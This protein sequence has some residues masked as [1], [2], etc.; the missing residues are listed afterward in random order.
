MNSILLLSLFIK[1]LVLNKSG[2]TS[3]FIITFIIIVVN[4]TLYL[5]VIKKV[6]I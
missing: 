3:I 6:T 4:L 2:Y 1:E 5:I